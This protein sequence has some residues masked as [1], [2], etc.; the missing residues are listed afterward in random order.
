VRGERKE[1]ATWLAVALVFAVACVFLGRWQYHRFQSKYR[2]DHTIGRNYRASPVPVT[3]LLPTPQ[4]TLPAS[5]EWRSVRITGTYDTSGQVLVRNRPFEG[6][7][8]YEVL[9]PL[10]PAGGGTALLIDRGWIP[11]GRTGV[12]PDA[13]PAVP[14]AS[15]TVTAHLRPGEVGRHDTLPVGQY[16][17]IDLD[18]IGAAYSFPILRA[19]GQLA[20]ESPKLTAAQDVGLSTLP[21]PDDGGYWGVNLSY[22]FQWGLFA[23]GGLAFPFVFRRR[24]RRLAAE[25]A[26]EEAAAASGIEYVPTRPRKR[27]IWD[28]EDE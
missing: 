15:V 4:S 23:I 24:R 13:V 9:V 16:S 27:R 22:A 17:S 8:G 26:A 12:A 18:R 5:L 28:D 7:F 19:Y 2:A 21:E 6:T 25:D 10:Q 3:Q 20:K 11:N 1:L 14:T